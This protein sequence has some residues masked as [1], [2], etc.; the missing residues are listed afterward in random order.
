MQLRYLLAITAMGAISGWANLAL[1]ESIKEQVPSSVVTAYCQSAGL[2]EHMATVTLADNTT[3]T[4][5]V[6]CEAGNMGSGG[7]AAGANAAVDTTAGQHDD[8]SK[9]T[10][11]EDSHTTT[12]S[13]DGKDSSQSSSGQQSSGSTSGSSGSGGD[14]GG[15]AG[16]DN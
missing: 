10:E 5:S 3:L 2:G 15:D 14:H 12:G 4:G 9:G 16:G 13:D 6:D 11:T 7:P 8:G 1:A